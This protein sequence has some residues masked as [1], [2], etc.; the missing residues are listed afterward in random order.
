MPSFCYWHAP[1]FLLLPLLLYCAP[2]KAQQP[3]T[4]LS[5]VSMALG[6]ADI[7]L[8]DPSAL[9]LNP[10]A[11]CLLKGSTLLAGYHSRFSQQY[12]STAYTG[13]ALRL[14]Q[15]GMAVGCSG[16]G[17]ALLRQEDLWAAYAHR[18]GSVSVG[19]RLHVWQLR[20]PEQASLHALGVDVG[21]QVP[22]S[23]QLQLA[24]L[25]TN[26]SQSSLPTPLPSPVPSWL[27]LGLQ[28]KA[29]PDCELYLQLQKE[30][31]Q[32]ASLQVGCCYRPLPALS[33][34]AGA[35]SAPLSLGT[36][37]GLRLR[38]FGL[39]YGLQT[40]PQLPLSHSLALHFQLRK[41]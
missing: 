7:C 3:E 12:W 2:A 18:I 26:A 27:K 17:S 11:L 25:L 6:G 13:I 31:R 41:P 5:P 28:Y 33:L 30:V 14:G 32:P 21:A 15:G 10:S 22:L 36:G 37:I 35:Q 1:F 8:S 23:E 29:L 40:H 38:R 19:A 20:A 9:L 24:C 4:S 16:M 39:D 34:R